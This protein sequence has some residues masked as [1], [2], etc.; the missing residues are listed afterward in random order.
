MTNLYT[1]DGEPMTWDELFE[2]VDA[3]RERH[4]RDGLRGWT[5]EDT[6]IHLSGPCS[7]GRYHHTC[8]GTMQET[9][10]KTGRRPCTCTC[11]EEAS[12]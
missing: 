2:R 11:H 4:G 12:A 3:F 5:P 8:S 1:L 10:G 6:G 9:P 7:I